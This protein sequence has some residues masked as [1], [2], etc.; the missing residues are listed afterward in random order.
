M[1]IDQVASSGNFGGGS[2]FLFTNGALTSSAQ[3]SGSNSISVTSNNTG[4]GAHNNVQPSQVTGISV[5][6]AA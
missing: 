2:I 4:G 5:I 6:R 3:F 1:V